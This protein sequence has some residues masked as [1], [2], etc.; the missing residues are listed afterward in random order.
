MYS[1]IDTN[2]CLLNNGGCTQLCTNTIGSYHCDC[3][4]GYQLNDNEISCN[5]QYIYL[6]FWII[7]FISVVSDINECTNGTDLCE[8]NCYNT[9]GS[10]VCDC[11]PGYQLSNGL[12]CSD[13]N[14]CDTSNGGCALRCVLIKLDHIIVNVIMDIHWMM[15]ITDAQVSDADCK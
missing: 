3:R 9:D 15:I 11:Q 8:H 1:F 4:S 2:E 6:N 13:I 10:Y 7:D 12:T 5:G 14:E